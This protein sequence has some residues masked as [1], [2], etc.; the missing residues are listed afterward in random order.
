[1]ITILVEDRTKHGLFKWSANQSGYWWFSAVNA[2]L[3]N[4]VKNTKSPL[5]A[6]EAM[7]CLVRFTSRCLGG[8]AD[9]AVMNAGNFHYF[10]LGNHEI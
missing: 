3:T 10:T 8:S 4:C 7:P 2:K 5:V 1:M 9:A 6:C